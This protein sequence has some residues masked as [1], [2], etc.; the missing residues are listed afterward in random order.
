MRKKLQKNSCLDTSTWREEM[1]LIKVAYFML[2]FL[3]LKS[4]PSYLFFMVSSSHSTLCRFFK[5]NIEQYNNKILTETKK[6][7]P[8]Q[9]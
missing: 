4:F 6:N 9:T 5:A 7:S 1:P 2:N 3:N 8:G